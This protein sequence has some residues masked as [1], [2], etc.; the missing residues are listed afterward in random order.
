[1]SGYWVSQE[2]H[3][4]EHCRTWTQGDA[5]SIRIHENGKKHK[6]NVQRFLAE[7]ERDKVKKSMQ[8]DKTA[9]L[10]RSVEAAAGAAMRGHAAFADVPPPPPLPPPASGPGGP[11]DPRRAAVWAALG[12]PPRLPDAYIPDRARRL[13][14]EA[15]LPL[16]MAVAAAPA[17]EDPLAKRPRV[18]DEPSS[19]GE[20]AGGSTAEGGSED[21]GARAGPRIGVG[22]TAS[23]FDAEEEE[24]VEEDADQ[25]ETG[26]RRPD[27]A[28][29]AEP[30]AAA[31]ATGAGADGGAAPGLTGGRRRARIVYLTG[32]GAA[33]YAAVPGA[34]VEARSLVYPGGSSS[35]SAPVALWE[36]G[37]VVRVVA[38]VGG[39]ER[40]FVVR[41]ATTLTGAGGE[42]LQADALRDAAE[43]EVRL[44]LGRREDVDAARAAGVDPAAIAAAPRAGSSGRSGEAGWRAPT[45]REA[46]ERALSRQRVAGGAAS[47]SAAG[48][49]PA[50]DGDEAVADEDELGPE[51]SGWETVAVREITQEQAAME[52]GTTIEDVNLGVDKLNAALFGGAPAPAP[53]AQSDMEQPEVYRGVRI[54]GHPDPVQ[55]QPPAS[56]SSVAEAEPLDPLGAPAAE[57]EPSVA[58]LNA[59]FKR[60]R[61]R[62][63]GA[64]RRR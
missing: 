35:G 34:Q 3:W 23:E 29:K 27:S 58:L 5:I 16:G 45:L 33:A 7:Q 42:A 61:V 53:P 28:V 25:G 26:R 12:A 59:G 9:A 2:K 22:L 62:T 8:E 63:K 47:D 4:C 54:S 14:K 21:D 39:G 10:L 56:G 51:P 52:A 43:G 48:A 13:M 18:D 38:P 46:T 44:R 36:Q 6:E 31:G 41:V 50:P 32:A 17:E 30:G 37:E 64:T 11:A 1:M 60:R 24:D 40:R 55:P 15:R 49:A 20:G 19:G 57:A